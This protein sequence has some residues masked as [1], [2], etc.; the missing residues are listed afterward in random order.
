MTV[1]VT[2]LESHSSRLDDRL[3]ISEGFLR[4]RAGGAE[5]LGVLALPLGER[6]GPGWVVSHSFG[7]EQVDLHMLDVAV[8][9]S[10]ASAGFPTLRFHSQGYGDSGDV[11]VPA[12]PTTQLRDTLEVIG[13]FTELAEVEGLGLIGARFG[14]TVAA[15]VAGR[16]GA[17]HLVLLH[18]IV[19]G[20][21]YAAELLRS[22]VIIELLGEK[23]AEA[24]T[25][26]RLKEELA[27]RGMVNIK[28]WPLRTDAYEELRAIDLVKEMDPFAGRALVVQV[29]RGSSVQGA[30]SRLRDRL[31]AMG[32][33]SELQVVTHPSAPNFGYEHFRPVARELLG[34]ILEGVNQ[35]LVE[36]TLQWLGVGEEAEGRAG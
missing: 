4:L 17:S 24:T 22:R 29:S 36:R 25:V 33:E 14:G 27:A 13:Q 11:W 20:S 8:A 23:P 5:T 6:R 32:A 21:R 34:D 1:D 10:L 35:A 30:M 16:A 3:R 2:L 18:P 28:G 7:S 31:R 12:S 15:L 19:S 26:E 9:R